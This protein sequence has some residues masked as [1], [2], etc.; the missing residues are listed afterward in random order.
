MQH[1]NPLCQEAAIENYLPQKGILTLKRDW[2]NA[3]EALCARLVLIKLTQNYPEIQIAWCHLCHN[4][5]RGHKIIILS[6]KNKLALGQPFLC[7]MRKL[8]LSFM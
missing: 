8:N 3:N 5:G 4:D 6:V 1:Y 7:L 2:S